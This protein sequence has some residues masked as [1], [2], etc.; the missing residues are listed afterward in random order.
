MLEDLKGGLLEYENIVEFLADIRK[1]FGREDEESVKV[2]KLRRLEQRGKT[3]EE[4]MQ[5]FRRVARES[6]YK[7]R[8]LVEEFKREINATICQRLIESEQQPGSIEQWYDRIITLDR[9][10]RK[11]KREE[12][13]LRGQRDNGAPT[14]RVNHGH[15]LKYGQR[16]RK[17][18][19]SRCQ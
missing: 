5:E 10:W 12:E 6:R 9:N 3:I 19:S 1:E 15:S 14:P 16:D 18:L 7:G 11:S 4:F 2:A 13:R 17:H 8:L